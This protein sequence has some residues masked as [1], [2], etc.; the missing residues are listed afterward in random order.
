MTGY[1]GLN[2]V[3]IDL[4]KVG[5]CVVCGRRFNSDCPHATPA[6]VEIANQFDRQMDNE[7]CFGHPIISEPEQQAEEIRSDLEWLSA[8]DDDGTGNDADLY[9]LA[10]GR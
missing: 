10:R 9:N 7:D 4:E 5:V 8:A 3:E 2:D 6:Q 1:N